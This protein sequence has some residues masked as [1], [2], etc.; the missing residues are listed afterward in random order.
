MNWFNLSAVLTIKM[1]FFFRPSF[2]EYLPF[3][4]NLFPS[5]SL[6]LSLPSFPFLLSHSPFV[7]A[8][9]SFTFL[10]PLLLLSFFSPSLVLS[11][12]PNLFLSPP[13]LCPYLLWAF[14][15][16]SLPRAHTNS[17]FSQK[18]TLNKYTEMHTNIHMNDVRYCCTFMKE[19]V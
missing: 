19:N 6:P 7:P 3:S 16:L 12:F 9:F 8:A 15:L 18:Q 10:I 17:C 11:L 2:H 14:L 1:I 13:P 5:F 4:L